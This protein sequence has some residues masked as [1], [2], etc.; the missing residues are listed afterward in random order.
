MTLS[1]CP[2]NLGGDARSAAG[3]LR[4][5]AIELDRE[6]RICRVGEAAVALTATEFQLL[7]ALMATPGRLLSRNQMAAAVWGAGAQ[8]SDRTLDSHLRNLRRKL[9]EA[10]LP[11]AVETVHAQGMRLGACG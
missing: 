5:G 9:A 2:R 10:G 1:P 11:D 3:A 6:S 7:E 4:H 8:Q